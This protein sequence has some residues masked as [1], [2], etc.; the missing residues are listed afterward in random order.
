MDLVANHTAWDSVMMTNKSFYKQ[1]ATGH[2]ISPDPGWTDV[3]GLNYANPELRQY[4]ITM[5]KY[6]IQ[7]CDVD[8]FRCDVAWGVPVDFWEQ[9]R[10][11]LEKT[12]P[13]IMLLAEA[14]KPNYLVKAFDL[15]YSWKLMWAMNDV[16]LHSAPAAGIRRSWEESRAQY[17]QGR[18]ASAHFRR[19]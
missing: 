10:G 1:D 12:K 19:S 4:M 11:E 17:S 3:A 9:A 16:L 15:D 18:P 7:T 6:W 13:D 14:E 8:G 5:L 2:V